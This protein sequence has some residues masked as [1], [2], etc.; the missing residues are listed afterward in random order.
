MPTKK[1]TKTKKSASKSSAAGQI[2]RK[3]ERPTH[4]RQSFSQAQLA[5]L[6]FLS[7]GTSYII[8]YAKVVSQG[9]ESKAC[10]AYLQ[11][12]ESCSDVDLAM[13]RIKYF[14]AII[15]LM[16]T[17]A[18]AFLCWNDEPLFL[19]LNL[20]LCASPLTASL[21]ALYA[22]RD[23]MIYD[24]AMRI[25]RTI[26]IILILI[27]CSILTAPQLAKPSTFR[28][29]SFQNISLIMLLLV[30]LREAV[31]LINDGPGA[32]IHSVSESDQAA[33]VVTV[34]VA[35]DN[36]TMCFIFAVAIYFFN[37]G[38]KRNFL[39]FVAMARLIQWYLYLPRIQDDL[40]DAESTRSLLVGG[41]ILA[42]AA[43][44][45]PSARKAKSKAS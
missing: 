27:L 29:G 7:I 13:I 9:V 45:A 5:A 25:G 39:L 20:F 40:I 28:L 34:F 15:V 38:R 10:H 3:A 18:T 30:H 22:S 44:F 31:R 14:G 42:G 19:R 43:G 24:K 23:V 12:V 32:L 41:A 33:H 16:L 4:N 36:L 11:G 35:V 6:I 26:G 1:K 37:D 2:D 17:A 8:E 21:V